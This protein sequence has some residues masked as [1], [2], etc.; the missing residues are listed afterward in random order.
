MSTGHILFIQK[1]FVAIV[2]TSDGQETQGVPIYYV[3]SEDDNAFYFITKKGTKK[4]INIEKNR[5]ASL[6]IYTDRPPIV[7]TANCTAELFDFQ[8]EQHASI[9]NQLVVIHSSQD[10]Y[11]SPISTLAGKDI[12]L[13]K[14]NMENFELKSYKEDIE[15]LLEEVSLKGQSK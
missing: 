7:F 15:L 4:F 14:L 9:A 3:F 12:S 8:S 6:T 5:K 1:Y 13:I 11:P 10:Y 2:S